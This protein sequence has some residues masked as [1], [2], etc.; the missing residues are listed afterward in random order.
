[1]PCRRSSRELPYII[2]LARLLAN[3]SDMI[4]VERAGGRH[5][6]ANA[7]LE[8]VPISPARHRHFTL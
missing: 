4:I 1:M 3:A 6:V 7:P 5:T 8:A 2:A